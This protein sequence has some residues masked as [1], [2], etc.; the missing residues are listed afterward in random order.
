MEGFG[1]RRGWEG[2]DAVVSEV[3]EVSAARGVEA[4]EERALM[5]GRGWIAAEDWT[6]ERLG[7]EKGALL[8]N[9]DLGFVLFGR[10]MA[11]GLSRG[12][13]KR[14]SDAGRL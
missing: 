10:E 11:A 5:R 7:L 3:V 1:G 2:C 4:E 12:R 6:A 8:W 13:D 14:F 9:F